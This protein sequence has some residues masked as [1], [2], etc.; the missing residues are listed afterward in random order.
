VL[1]PSCTSTTLYFAFWHNPRAKLVRLPPSADT[2]ILWEN[3][4][5]LFQT[6]TSCP[7]L[8]S[9]A[10]RVFHCRYYTT[11][12]APEECWE[13]YGANINFETSH[14]LASPALSCCYQQFSTKAC[15]GEIEDSQG[16]YAGERQLHQLYHHRKALSTASSTPRSTSTSTSI[17]LAASCFLHCRNVSAPTSGLH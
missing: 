14:L 2:F 11:R 6:H 13:L 16:L 8:M 5:K 7:P 3:N 1:E 12:R 15:E 9:S 4:L 10:Y 17:Y